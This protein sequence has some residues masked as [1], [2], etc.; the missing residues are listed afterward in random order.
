[1]TELARP[2]SPMQQITDA[3]RNGWES[4]NGETAQSAYGAWANQMLGASDSDDDDEV[5]Q[6]TEENPV[7]MDW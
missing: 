3:D 1:M 6:D 2:F 4:D 5:T 7:P